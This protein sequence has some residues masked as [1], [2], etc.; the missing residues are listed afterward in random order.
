MTCTTSSR[1]ARNTWIAIAIAAG[2]IVCMAGLALIGGGIFM[3][4]RYMSTSFIAPPDALAEFERA[5]AQ[6]ADQ[7]PLLELQD[8]EIVVHRSPDARRRQIEALHV[9]AYDPRPGKLVNV[10]VPGWLLRILPERGST[11]TVNG[12]DVIKSSGGRISVEDL[13]RH[14]PGLILDGQE[15]SGSRVLVW[16]E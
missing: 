16:T 9:L 8:E 1:S 6:L 5:R 13:E 7:S 2:V 11:V 12:V 10:T 3:M 15:H 14:G 4:R